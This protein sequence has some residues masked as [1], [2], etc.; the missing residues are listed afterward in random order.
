VYTLEFDARASA[1][2]T[3]VVAALQAHD[4]WA[5]L[6]DVNV[7]L[8]DQWQHFSF[9]VSVKASEDNG[10]LNFGNLGAA[11]GTVEIAG[12]SLRPGGGY[13]LKPGE[14]LGTMGI[15]TKAE[16]GGLNEA[17][18]DDWMRFLY[19]T[20]AAY[21]TGMAKFVKGDL[22]ARS[23]I[24][25]TAVGFSPP[26]IQAQLDV[27]DGH[28]YWQH[29][30]FPGMPWDAS[31]WFVRNIPMAGVSGGGTLP[32]LGLSRVAGKPFIVT[33]YNHPAPNTHSSE[34]FLLAAGYAGLQ[35][36]DGFFSYGYEGDRNLWRA[37]WVTGYFD[38]EHHPT[39]MAMMPAA[40]ALFL[41]GD[42]ASPGDGYFASTTPEKA[43]EL[44]ARFGPWYN[45]G[46]L[47]VN[48]LSALQRPVGLRLD[49]KPS[50]IGT[51][52]TGERIVSANGQWTWDSTKGRECV[53]INAPRSKAFVGS[54]GG[55]PV[56]LG[57]VVVAPGKNLQDWAAI[58]LT[59]L[60]GASFSAPGRILVTA[61]GY[62]ENTSMGW[63]DEAKTTVGP[64]W[65]IGPTLVEGIPATITLPV[66][67]ARV[68]VWAL[69]ERGQ[70]REQVP[71]R[72]VG[73]KAGFEIGAKYKTLWYE[74]VIR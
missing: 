29:P 72:D 2:R 28:A 24:V 21:W 31:N 56:Q 33:E 8:T 17:M 59:A 67:A 36:W 45:A 38:V 32:A 25:G 41:R 44:V 26:S 10:R 40:A 27:V 60:D 63:K 46:N 74:A 22:G 6:W 73:G 34:A 7:T 64:D 61:T 12:V 30:S 70:R 23:L 66:T 62:A 68:T 19:E 57:D 18:R 49:G 35:D 1:K 37:S 13:K 15:I 71:V 11:T 65:G 5:W 55:G 47:G 39:Q 58:T 51:Q 4:P 20:E 52:P 3:I 14:G 53:Q 54:T 48:T 43:V 69:D 42:L 9:P 16:S 50:I